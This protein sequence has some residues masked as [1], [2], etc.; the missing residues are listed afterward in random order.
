MSPKCQFGATQPPAD[1]TIHNRPSRAD[2]DYTSFRTDWDTVLG[3]RGQFAR[4]DIAAGALSVGRGARIALCAA[5]PGAG[6]ESGG[7]V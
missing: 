7:C 5:H 4:T 6:W 3:D 1:S 2:L